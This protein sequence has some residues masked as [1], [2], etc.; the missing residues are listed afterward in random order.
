MINL[1]A[2]HSWYTGSFLLLSFI[3]SIDYLVGFLY[4]KVYQHTVVTFFVKFCSGIMNRIVIGLIRSIDY[5]SLMLKKVTDKV[6]AEIQIWGS[7]VLSVLSQPMRKLFKIVQ[8]ACSLKYLILF[9]LNRDWSPLSF[10]SF[11]SF[12]ATLS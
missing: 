2:E 10:H 7:F 11:L 3:M 8:E 4:V 5:F 6:N 12:S 9:G 1:K